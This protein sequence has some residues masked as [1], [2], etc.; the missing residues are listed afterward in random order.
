M[1]TTGNVILHNF[2]L[3]VLGLAACLDYLKRTQLGALFTINFTAALFIVS[4]P[5]LL[6]RDEQLVT[7]LIE[8]YHQDSIMAAAAGYPLLLDRI[9]RLLDLNPKLPVGSICFGRDHFPTYSESDASLD[10]NGKYYLIVDIMVD[11]AVQRRVVPMKLFIPYHNAPSRRDEY[12][13]KTDM[14]PIFFINDDLS[15]GFSLSDNRFSDKIVDK[16]VTRLVKTSPKLKFSWPGYPEDVRQLRYKKAADEKGRI[17]IGTRRLAKL[18]HGAVS[19][20]L[21]ARILLV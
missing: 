6:D 15:I 7:K 11:P 8:D 9:I 18:V 20:F 4:Q 12:L 16:E 17:S 21:T 3:S 5:Q 13:D 14:L 10:E 19:N 1:C 2:K